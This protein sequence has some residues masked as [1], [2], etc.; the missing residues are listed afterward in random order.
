M[1]AKR[2][3]AIVGGITSGR[4]FIGWSRYTGSESVLEEIG[5]EGDIDVYVNSQ[6]GSVFAGF[7]ILNAL[8]SA[9]A[10]GRS[11]TIYVSAMA[12]SIASYITSGVKGAKVYMTDNAKLMFHAPWTSVTGSREELLDTADLLAKMEIDI[13]S[14][15]KNRGAKPE[16]EWFAAG[17]MKWFNAEEAI[18]R[19]LADG[20]KDPP[21]DLI[22]HVVTTGKSSGSSSFWW[23]SAGKDAD[24]KAKARDGFER[25]AAT[26]EFT[27]FLAGLCKDHYGEET[28]IV[29][30]GEKMFRAVRKDGASA[31]LKYTADPLNIVAIEWESAAFEPK[32]ETEMKKPEDIEAEAKPKAEADAK[33]KAEADTAKAQADAKI[34]AEAKAKAE[35][36][37]KAKAEADAAEAKAKE[38]ADTKAKAEADKTA[39]L[40]D[41][42]VAYAM[43][44]YKAEREAHATA[45]RA[46]DG[47]DF[48]DAEL[49]GFSIEV[50]AKIAA[51]A[52]AASAK[53]AE[54]PVKASAATPPIAPAPAAKGTAGG[55]LPP[56]EA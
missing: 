2:K 56:P 9:T 1:S 12:A 28:T 31:L 37:A 47:V 16:K 53:R 11:V 10:A 20:V 39:G 43:K 3:V 48:S 24:G 22:A 21:S 23:D 38:E 18:G 29:D 6:G 19:K 26:A 50:L 27:G 49:D 4:S 36:D 33:A 42:M 45:I 7:E 41:D 8:N 51:I 14:A 52:K 35:A 25:I 15:I 32:S 40:T 54:Q 5:S 17:R 30:V 13:E 55:T 34:E 46:I 44:N